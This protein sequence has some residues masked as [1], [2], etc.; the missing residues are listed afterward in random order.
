[1]TSS[2]DIKTEINNKIHMANGYYFGLRG[3]FKSKYL[4]KETKIQLYKT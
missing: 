1:M 3:Q 2:N 4:S